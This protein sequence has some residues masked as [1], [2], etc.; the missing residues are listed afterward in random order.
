M[1]EMEVN[2]YATNLSIKLTPNS[3]ALKLIESKLKQLCGFL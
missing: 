3:N 2:I 1:I